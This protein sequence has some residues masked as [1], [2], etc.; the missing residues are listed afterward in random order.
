MIS[1]LAST[2]F[3]ILVFIGLALVISGTAIGL[4]FVLAKAKTRS[5]KG[6]CL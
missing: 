3:P 1:D 2:Y 4:S 6:L 5:R